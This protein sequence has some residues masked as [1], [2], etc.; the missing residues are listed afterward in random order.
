MACGVPVV[1]TDVSDNAYV[2]RD[3][4]TGF[5]VPLGDAGAMASRIVALLG[6]PQTRAAMGTRAR[7]WVLSEFSP[8]AL[9][10]RMAAVYDEAVA[11]RRGGLP[12]AAATSLT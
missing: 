1:V 8:A 3:G 9:A 4:E 10:T 12:R 6:S 2:V 11:R 5:V 7:Q